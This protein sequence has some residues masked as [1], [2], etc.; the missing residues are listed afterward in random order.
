MIVS[1]AAAN[2]DMHPTRIRLA[3]ISLPV[4]A[5]VLA[6]HAREARLAHALSP[7]APTRAAP[8]P[9][10]LRS[11]LHRCGRRAPRFKASL[12]ET[13][14]RRARRAPGESRRYARAELWARVG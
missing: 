4:C 7:P 6:H 12:P 5:F 14:R 13:R 10:R 1:D 2:N 3:L 11:A 9:L 8:H